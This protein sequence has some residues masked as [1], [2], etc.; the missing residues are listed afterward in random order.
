MLCQM[1]RP[2]DVVVALVKNVQLNRRKFD[3]R[4][5]TPWSSLIHLKVSDLFETQTVA[6]TL[7]ALIRRTPAEQAIASMLGQLV[8]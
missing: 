4:R 5:R 8:S 3:S 1:Q 6:S 7:E 2:L